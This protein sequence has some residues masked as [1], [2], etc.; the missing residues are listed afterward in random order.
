LISSVNFTK[1]KKFTNPQQIPQPAPLKLSIHTFAVAALRRHFQEW[2][3]YEK[4]RKGKKR[5]GRRAWMDP[6]M[7]RLLESWSART[8]QAFFTKLL[9]TVLPLAARYGVY[10]AVDHRERAWPNLILLMP[11]FHFH[12]K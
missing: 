9:V 12:H 8:H 5:K 2:V 4:K 6:W 7:G 10:Y 1:N 3:Q 11:L